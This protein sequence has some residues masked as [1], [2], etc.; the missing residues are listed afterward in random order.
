[1][2]LNRSNVARSLGRN[3]PKLTVAMWAVLAA[4]G[5]GDD[6]G[7]STTP[8]TM[9]G[10]G[11]TAGTGTVAGTGVAA[12]TGAA[13]TAVG[14]AGTAAGAAG[15]TTGGAA[16]MVATTAG[17]GAGPGAA[18]TLQMVYD[19][20]YIASC[21]VCHGMKPTP[22]ANG[23]L[24]DIKGSKDAFYNALVN[25]PAL[26]AQCTG[27]GMYI[28]PGQPAQSLLIQKIS[29]ATPP[30]G[31]QMPPTGPLQSADIK[32]VTDWVMAGALNN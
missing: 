18:P 13:G 22:T 11:A 27:K 20:V 3:L 30:C 15:T 8:T 16:G 29:Q 31:T 2:T 10:A 26:G 9:A 6:S 28:V 1:V 5:C 23:N 14:A 4:V 25:K 12:G 21:A 7:T 24:G 32:L 19:S 17:T